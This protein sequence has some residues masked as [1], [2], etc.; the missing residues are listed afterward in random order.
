MLMATVAF[1]AGD[2]IVD[3]KL[4]VG[5]GTT[6]PDSNVVVNANTAAPQTALTGTTLHL[7][8]EDL[9]GQRLL[10]DSYGSWNTITFRRADNTAANPQNVASGVS[11]GAIAAFGYGSTGYSS[12]ARANIS[13]NTAEQWNNNAQGTYLSFETTPI[14]S[15]TKSARMRIADNG[16][17]GIGTTTPQAPWMSLRG[18]TLEI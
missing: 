15:T 5:T 16:N 1:A 8:A 12:S 14:G 18:L 4:G 9:T 3:G 11:L 6:S 7:S 13:F 17:V 10:I 2:L